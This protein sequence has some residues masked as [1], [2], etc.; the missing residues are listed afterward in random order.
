[1]FLELQFFTIM[2]SC[3]PFYLY[4]KIAASVIWILQFRKYLNDLFS[5]KMTP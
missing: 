3:H 2:M 5:P 4:H 1:M